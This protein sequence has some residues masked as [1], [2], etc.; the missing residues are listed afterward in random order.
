MSSFVLVGKSAIII[1]AANRKKFKK[2]HLTYSVKHRLER[3]ETDI[4]FMQN[5]S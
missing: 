1:G 5:G 4:F 2:P 3:T